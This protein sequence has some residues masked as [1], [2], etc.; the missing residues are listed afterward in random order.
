MQ[1]KLRWREITVFGGETAVLVDLE[2]LQELPSKTFH[3]PSVQATLSNQAW[4]TYADI[5]T[6]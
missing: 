3:S 4:H 1:P 2:K 6:V 5:A